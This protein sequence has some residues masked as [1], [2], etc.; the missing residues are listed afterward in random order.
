M[1]A[2]RCSFC[3]RNFLLVGSL[4]FLSHSHSNNTNAF[5]HTIYICFLLD[6]AKVAS[7]VCIYNYVDMIIWLDFISRITLLH[8]VIIIHHIS[9]VTQM[10]GEFV[11]FVLSW[12]SLFI[13]ISAATL[14]LLLLLFFLYQFR[15]YL[16]YSNIFFLLIFRKDYFFL[17]SICNGIEIW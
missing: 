17:F 5:H 14:L 3:F 15:V 13:F 8:I 6:I 9:R 7:Q 16:L 1:V 12:A 10:C 2:V 11:V 4:F